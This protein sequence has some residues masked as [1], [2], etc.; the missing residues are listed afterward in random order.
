[1]IR[2]IRKEYPQPGEGLAQMETETDMRV[3]GR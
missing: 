3:P 1:M 2:G